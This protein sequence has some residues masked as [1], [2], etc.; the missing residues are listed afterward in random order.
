VFKFVKKAYDREGQSCTLI[1]TGPPLGTDA[2]TAL[3]NITGCKE[4]TCNTVA[5]FLKLGQFE[6]HQ[7]FGPIAFKKMG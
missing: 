3:N 4:S 7:T 1:A 6:F 5:S 2:Q